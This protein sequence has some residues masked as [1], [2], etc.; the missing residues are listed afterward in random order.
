MDKIKTVK[1]KNL[2]GSISE[3]SYTICTDA[4][5]VDMKNGYNVQNSIGDINVDADGN[6]SNQLKNKI[7]ISDIID[8]LDSNN[9][10]KVLSARQGKILNDSI[11]KKPF[12]YNNIQEM[13][14]DNILYKNSM[15]ITLGYYEPNDGGAGEYIIRDRIGLSRTQLFNKNNA[16]TVAAFVNIETGQYRAANN[17]QKSLLIKLEHNK[18][19]TISGFDRKSN[20]G[21][22]ENIPVENSTYATRFQ[23]IQVDSSWTF[24]TSSTETYLVAL[25]T[26]GST[27]ITTYDNVMLNYGSIALPYEDYPEDEDGGS[28]LFLNNDL[29]AEL[30]VKD[31]VSVKQFG[32]KGNNQADDTEAIQQAINLYKKIYIPDGIYKISNI[33]LPSDREI[34]GNGDNSTLQS[35]NNNI[36]ENLIETT[37]S[38]NKCIIRDLRIFGDNQIDN[39]IYLKRAQG[40]QEGR[41]DCKHILDNLEIRKFNK[42]GIKMD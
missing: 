8:N 42:I 41:F 32:A 34:K 36:N 37:E 39:A 29:V 14:N 9:N 15:A 25:Y 28:V 7:N 10:N 27:N 12:Y 19:Y 1:I 24:T 33:I 23:E 2:D 22:F 4:Q 3:N 21:L 16:N 6:V 38:A 20:M 18:T 5:Y 17:N 13:K 40:T 30:I 26:G 31:Y 35:I 11:E